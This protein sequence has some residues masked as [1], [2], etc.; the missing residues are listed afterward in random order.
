MTLPSRDFTNLITEKTALVL[1]IDN[2]PLNVET[3]GFV[4]MDY[5]SDG[6]IAEVVKNQQSSTIDQN[7]FHT[8]NFGRK[9]FIS[10]FKDH[11]SLLAEVDDVIGLLKANS[12]TKDTIVLAV[13]KDLKNI[14][15][16]LPELNKRYKN[17]E[18][19]VFNF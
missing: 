14:T 10:F 6:L 5:L 7:T 12:E 8:F 19:L 16:I 11:A 4:E 9:F 17:F 18:F 1:W 15:D 2:S 3:P 13:K